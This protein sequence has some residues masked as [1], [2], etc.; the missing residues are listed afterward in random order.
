M[1]SRPGV[2]CLFG[3]LIS[4]VINLGRTMR[5]RQ[6]VPVKT[7]VRAATVLHA[8]PEYIADIQALEAYVKVGGHWWLGKRYLQ[9][10]RHRHLQPLRRKSL[11]KGRLKLERVVWTMVTIRNTDQ[12]DYRAWGLS[13]QAHC[14][15]RRE[16]SKS[17]WW[18]PKTERFLSIRTSLFSFKPGKT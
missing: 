9:R 6:R 17:I 8:D 10:D 5:E 11:G 16:G 13:G 12:S 18:T 4:V 3:L 2:C 7:P 15:Q 1:F 14:M